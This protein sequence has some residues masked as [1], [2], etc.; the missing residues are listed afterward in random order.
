MLLV[1]VTIALSENPPLLWTGRKALLVVDQSAV[2]DRYRGAA[3][4]AVVEDASAAGA[5]V[6]EER[7]VAHREGGVIVVDASPEEG[8]VA[9]ERAVAHRKGGVIVVDASAEEIRV[10]IFNSQTGNGDGFARAD[11]EHAV[12]VAAVYC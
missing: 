12:K 4:E 11:V 6:A 8:E 9:E 10:A 3:A 5:G 1:M 2:A 7:A